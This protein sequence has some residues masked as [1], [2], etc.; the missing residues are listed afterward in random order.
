MVRNP[1][2]RLPRKLTAVKD[3][4][5]TIMRP[6]FKLPFSM[7]IGIGNELLD[8]VSSAASTGTTVMEFRGGE[9]K[10]S[11]VSVL[12]VGTNSIAVKNSDIIALG[13]DSVKERNFDVID[14]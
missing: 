4:M 13:I 1:L 6:S 3:A 7:S 8:F 2:Q 10:S 12:L 9:D 14:V 5:M 11:D